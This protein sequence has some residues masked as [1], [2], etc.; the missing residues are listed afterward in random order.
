M[1]FVVFLLQ[2]A[3][4]E[5]EQQRGAFDAARIVNVSREVDLNLT[6]SD[7]RRVS[8][9]ELDATIVVSPYKLSLEF[10]LESP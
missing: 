1:L 2:V 10:S 6:G 5:A 9:H 8:L 4:G 3:L 7:Q